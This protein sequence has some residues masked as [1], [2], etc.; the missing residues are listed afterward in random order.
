MKPINMSLHAKN[1]VP[2][3]HVLDES[4][5]SFSPKPMP[6]PMTC[7]TQTHPGLQLSQPGDAKRRSLVP[8]HAR[9]PLR[10]AQR[11]RVRAWQEDLVLPS[12][13]GRVQDQRHSRALE[14]VPQAL[15]LTLRQEGL[16]RPSLDYGSCLGQN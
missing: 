9:D 16:E 1:G 5:E 2:R 12:Q 14:L 15:G 6:S 11:P 4:L 10:R 3:I 8:A 7:T 13:E